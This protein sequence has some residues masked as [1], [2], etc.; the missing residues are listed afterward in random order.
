MVDS[1]LIPP[2]G[3]SKPA[4]KPR[5]VPLDKAPSKRRQKQPVLKKPK[6]DNDRPS[7]DEYA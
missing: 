4:P 6:Q 7:I 2:V 5:A 3:S 1:T